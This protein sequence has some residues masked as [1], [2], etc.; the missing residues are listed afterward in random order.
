M[1]GQ[2]TNHKGVASAGI[3]NLLDCGTLC[4]VIEAVKT[5]KTAIT[6]AEKKTIDTAQID[7]D[8]MITTINSTN[9]TIIE[10]FNLEVYDFL[11]IEDDE[12]C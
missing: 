3:K 11:V 7:G 1:K 5:I 10:Q 4:S 12:Y 6:A 9:P 8:G 2:K